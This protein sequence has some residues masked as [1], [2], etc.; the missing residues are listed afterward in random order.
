MRRRPMEARRMPESLLLQLSAAASR[1]L[2]WGGTVARALHRPSHFLASGDSQH[3][4]DAELIKQR[5]RL[6]T[7]PSPLIN[8]PTGAARETS[9]PTA[10]AHFHLARRVA[11]HL[12][13]GHHMAV[14]VLGPQLETWSDACIDA[15]RLLCF[16]WD[17]TSDEY[18][19]PDGG[20]QF[21]RHGRYRIQDLSSAGLDLASRVPAD[22]GLVMTDAM[23]KLATRLLDG[24]KHAQPVLLEGQAA[25]GKTAAV[26]FCAHRT[27]SPMTRFNMTPNTT[28]ADFVGQLGLSGD[29]DLLLCLGPFAEAVKDGQAF[30]GRGEPRPG[31]CAPCD[32]RCAQPRLPS[33]WLGWRRGPA[34]KHQRPAH[35]PGAPQF[36]AL[37]HAKLGGRRQVRHDAPRAVSVVTLSLCAGGRA[38]NGDGAAA[39]HRAQQAARVQR[40]H[41]HAASRVAR[42]W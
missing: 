31:R 24:A 14:R 34:G 21:F 3:T 11:E 19:W 2:H 35:H 6:C 25:G 4:A 33:A 13:F 23:T 32:R 17:R 7:P 10:R 39:L 20:Q 9:H 29:D 30:A 18:G 42:Q 26:A 22:P 12:S 5:Q 41:R 37:R 36:S 40:L 15:Q 1:P 16:G 27:N 28:I 38:G 8:A